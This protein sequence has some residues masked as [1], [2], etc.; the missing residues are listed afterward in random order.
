[1]KFIGF[2]VFLFTLQSLA[3]SANL[4]EQKLYRRCYM[5][6]VQAPIPLKDPTFTQIKAGQLKAIDACMNLL[7]EAT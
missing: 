5:Q 6:L 7:N 3:N 4:T 1:M 2:L